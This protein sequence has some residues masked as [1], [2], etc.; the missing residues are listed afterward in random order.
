MASMLPAAPAGPSCGLPFPTRRMPSG[1]RERASRNRGRT[2]RVPALVTVL[3]WILMVSLLSPGV[4]P[5]AYAQ[6][7]FGGLLTGVE[8]MIGES[9]AA[10]VIEE[11]GQPVRLSPARQK[12]VDTIFNDIV[13][14]AKRRKEI[15]YRLSILDS[16]VVNA[17][18]APGGYIFITTGLLR[19][20][21]DDA[22]ALANVLGHEVAHVEH[23]HGMN[24]LMRQLG[25]GFVL[26]LLFGGSTEVVR[27]VAGVAMSLIHLGWSREQEHESDDTGQRMAAAAG[28]D[29]EGMVRFFTVIQR[30]EGEETPQLEF[31]RTHPLTS[32]RIQRARA[33]AQTLKATSASSSSASTPPGSSSAVTSSA[34]SPPGSSGGNAGEPVAR[35]TSRSPQHT[36]QDNRSDN[37]SQHKS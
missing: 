23:K 6:D 8:V 11:Y 4:A 34:S 25:T 13:A 26:Q 9:V 1:S 29:P 32:E 17:F 12:W 27:Q 20:I 28:Y 14:R 2:S 22:D 16:Q 19:H 31:L 18:A 37:S 24:T 3:I 30:L 33:R 21:G 10:S 36:T 35:V 15:T 7:L 5:A